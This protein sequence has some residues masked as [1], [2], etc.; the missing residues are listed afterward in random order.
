MRRLEWVL[1]VL[2]I[3]LVI[4]YWPRTTTPDPVPGDPLSIYGISLGMTRAEVE[5]RLGP[6]AASWRDD[7]YP[8]FP[9]VNYRASRDSWGEPGIQYSP[10]G[11]V[12]WVGGATLEWPGGKVFP[13]QSESSLLRL[14]PAGK[15]IKPPIYHPY[16]PGE[17]YLPARR[18]VLWIAAPGIFDSHQFERAELAVPFLN[19]FKE[20]SG[21]AICDKTGPLFRK[22][23]RALLEHVKQVSCLCCL[24]MLKKPPVFRATGESFCPYCGEMALLADVSPEYLRQ[25]HDAWLKP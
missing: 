9:R 19:G 4:R 17:Y 10:E 21:N 22:P 12:A 25:V 13:K 3:A 16:M 2:L 11:R 7:I 15:Q 6:P 14:F 8:S 23:N 24:R 20:V 1:T 5:K 18:L